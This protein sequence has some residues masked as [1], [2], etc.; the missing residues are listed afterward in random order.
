MFNL[1]QKSDSLKYKMVLGWASAR[2][3]AELSRVLLGVD[4]RQTDLQTSSMVR[5]LSAV[6]LWLGAGQSWIKVTVGHWG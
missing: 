4:P 3:D 2:S 1:F 5:S 6:W